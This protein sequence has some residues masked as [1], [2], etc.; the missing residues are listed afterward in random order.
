MRAEGTPAADAPRRYADGATITRQGDLVARP[1]LIERGLVRLSAVADDGREVVLGLLGPGDVLDDCALLG[2]RSPVTASAAQATSVRRLEADASPLTAALARRLRATTEQLEEAM[3]HD[4]RTRLL[5][6]LQ[7]LAAGRHAGVRLPLTQDELGRMI[8]A[9]RETVNRALRDLTG[10]G[11][12]DAE[13]RA[14]VRRGPPKR[15]RDG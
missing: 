11:A 15:P 8:G 6:R 12:L 2:E 14:A 5:R 1:G 7:D 13:A 4:V 9:S 10:R 3:L